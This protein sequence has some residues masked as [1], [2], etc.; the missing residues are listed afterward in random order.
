MAVVLYHKLADIGVF[1]GDVAFNNI[2]VDIDRRL[3]FP[4]S[5]DGIGLVDSVPDDRAGVP[6]IG[7]TSSSSI[8]FVDAGICY[9]VEGCREDEGF[10]EE[11]LHSVDKNEK[12]QTNVSRSP[13]RRTGHSYIIR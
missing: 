7:P 12:L 8:P 5:T 11:E 6:G 4:R 9:R 13:K 2:G 1:Q 10:D 3:I